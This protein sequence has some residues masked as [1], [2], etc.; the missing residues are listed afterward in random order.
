MKLSKRL[1]LKQWEAATEAIAHA[2]ADA[3]VLSSTKDPSAKELLLGVEVLK[4]LVGMH[5]PA[6][7][8]RVRKEEEE[9]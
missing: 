2:Q 1:T 6:H 5:L 3:E 8:Y 4:E 7:V 9:E